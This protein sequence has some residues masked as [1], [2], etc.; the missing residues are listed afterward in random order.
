MAE[1]FFWKH[2]TYH[3]LYLYE[4]TVFFT[5]TQRNYYL[6]DVRKKKNIYRTFFATTNFQLQIMYSTGA[7]EIVGRVGFLAIHKNRKPRSCQ[8]RVSLPIQTYNASLAT[9]LNCKSGFKNIIFGF[10]CYYIYFA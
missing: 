4:F 3:R 10:V 9:A 2:G 1:N 6:F 8:F 5:T 7:K